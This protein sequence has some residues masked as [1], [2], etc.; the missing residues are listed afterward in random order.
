MTS[1]IK[2][3]A[4]C[5]DDKVVEILIDNPNGP[6][7]YT[8]QNGEV[9]EECFYDDIEIKVKE[10]DTRKA[11]IDGVF[12]VL[13]G[14]PKGKG[15]NRMAELADELEEYDFHDSV[16]REFLSLLE[17]GSIEK[18]PEFFD[19]CIKW[20][21]NI[22]GSRDYVYRS[23]KMKLLI[24]LMLDGD[25]NVWKFLPRTLGFRDAVQLYCETQ[26]QRV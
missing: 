5:A 2:V 18:L 19:K 23:D 8:L 13:G 20:N 26:E 3:I 15:S 16:V 25:M 17:H 10:V 6:S 4:C 21:I 11:E 1:M 22:I 24:N 14:T 7:I 12:F 9:L